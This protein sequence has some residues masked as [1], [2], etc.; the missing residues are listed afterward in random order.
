MK[1][2]FQ[3]PSLHYCYTNLA[4]L[5]V[6][7]AKSAGTMKY[8]KNKTIVYVLCYFFL[9]YSCA[10]LK[11]HV[12]FSPKFRWFKSLPGRCST[13]G[14]VMAQGT[15]QLFRKGEAHPL[16]S[17]RPYRGERFVHN[18]RVADA[19]PQQSISTSHTTSTSPSHSPIFPNRSGL[20]KRKA[21]PCCKTH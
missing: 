13:F 7:I 14:Q 19:L 10:N 20:E 18:T 3:V 11:H 16:S 5:F 8:A 6:N 12:Q 4:L 2:S 15:G 9:T 17:F 1:S 21:H